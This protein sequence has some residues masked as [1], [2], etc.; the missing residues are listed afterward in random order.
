MMIIGVNEDN[1]N[2]LI[3]LVEQVPPKVIAPSVKL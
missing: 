3:E 1:T 2:I